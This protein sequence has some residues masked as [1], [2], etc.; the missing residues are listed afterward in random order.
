MHK[1]TQQITLLP[2]SSPM[3][4]QEQNWDEITFPLTHKWGCYQ[5]SLESQAVIVPVLHWAEKTDPL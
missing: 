1:H 2:D 5:V 3:P 4:A